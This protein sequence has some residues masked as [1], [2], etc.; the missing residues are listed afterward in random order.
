VDKV[1]A[2]CLLGVKVGASLLAAPFPCR[3]ADSVGSRSH[4]SVTCK[5]SLERSTATICA[6]RHCPRRG[7]GHCK[8]LT[9][10]PGAVEG[11]SRPIAAAQ[12]RPPDVRPDAHVR[13]ACL[14]VSP[15]PSMLHAY[16]FC[17]K[18]HRGNLLTSSCCVLVSWRE[19][20]RLADYE[21]LE[22]GLAQSVQF[23]ADILQGLQRHGSTPHRKWNAVGRVEACL[24]DRYTHVC[25]SRHLGT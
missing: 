21:G 12:R 16:R 9:A 18:C 13:S 17:R 1:H 19:F 14:P 10:L 15:K 11:R 2:R 23:L 24:Y 6:V 5:L 4:F 7:V 20:C 22:R 3:T 8:R 25:W